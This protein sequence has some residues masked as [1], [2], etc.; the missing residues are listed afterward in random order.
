MTAHPRR[1]PLLLA[2]A[3][4]LLAGPFQGGPALAEGREASLRQQAEA[5]ARLSGQQRQQYF[6]ARR[7]LDQRQ[8]AQ[9][10]MALKESE[11]CVLQARD[12]TAVERCL[13]RFL[14]STRESRR[15]Q[16]EQLA[17]LQRRFNLP[18]WGS[19]RAGEKG[20]RPKPVRTQPAGTQGS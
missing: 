20:G 7:D 18:D 8:A 5:M 1:H 12:A 17:Q 4:L 19:D 16:M 13:K 9:R 15:S 11:S 6:A 3:L 10:Q 14:R 2:A